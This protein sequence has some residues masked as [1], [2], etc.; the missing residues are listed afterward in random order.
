MSFNLS[1]RSLM[2]GTAAA[3]VLAASGAPAI[4]APSVG[5][6]CVSVS[7]GQHI[8]YVGWSDSF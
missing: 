1:R 2:Q 6:R 3:G 7:R 4:A 5:A 8:R